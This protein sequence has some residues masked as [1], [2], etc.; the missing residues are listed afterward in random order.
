MFF[1]TLSIAKEGIDDLRRHRLDRVE[2]NRETEV[3]RAQLPSVNGGLDNIRNSKSSQISSNWISIKWKDANVGDI[4]RLKRDEPAPADLVLLSSAGLNGIT[5]V[6]TMALDGE[7]NLKAKQVVASLAS[8]VA[9]SE[10]IGNCTAEFVIEDPN[11]DLYNFNGRV[12]MNGSSSPLTNTEI[13]YRGSI[14]R[15][16]PEALAMII[17]SGEECKIRM[18]ANKNP[19]IKAPKLQKL[20]NRV[21]IF[22]VGF[23]LFL[24]IFCTVAHQIWL[25]SNDDST[26]YLFGARVSLFPLF[27]SFVIML[28]TM[29]PL[30]LYVSLEIIKLAQMFLLNDIDMYD[31][32]SNIPFEARTSTIN[33]ELGQVR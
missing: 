12:T 9:A 28:N 19:R 16:T 30:S 13:I 31:E 25:L 27:A 2:N 17:Y 6:E 7:T 20:L 3:L 8:S 24:A 4:V 32:K 11:I 10:D 26:D 21:V 22:I 15:N 5:Y 23:V 29:I 14:L 1:V 18:N 33:E